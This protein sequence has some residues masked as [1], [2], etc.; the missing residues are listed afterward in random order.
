MEQ[1][2]ESKPV[3]LGMWLVL[4]V[5]APAVLFTMWIALSHRLSGT[6]DIGGILIAGLVGCWPI[7]RL[8]I[9]TAA[10]VGLCFGYL[11]IV[12]VLLFLYG[13]WFVCAAYRDCL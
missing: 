10:R 8:R 3:S 12:C 7:T 4:S 1:Q 5:V 6:T 9:S 11:F 2:D 13:V